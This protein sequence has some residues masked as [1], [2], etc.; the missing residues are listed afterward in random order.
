MEITRGWRR[1]ISVIDALFL[2]E[3]RARFSSSQA[4]LFW[5]FFQ[6]FFMTSMFLTMHMVL[7]GSDSSSN[8]VYDYAVFLVLSMTSFFLFRDTLG[9]SAGAFTG[10]KS[11]F[12]YRRVKPVDTIVARMLVEIFIMSIIMSIFIIIGFYLGRDM[13]AKNLGMV[14]LG[15]IWL[16]VFG[17]GLG[18]LVAIG[19]VFY[20]FVGKLVGYISMPLLFLSGV[21]Y[22]IQSVYQVSPDVAQLL[23]YNPLVH[24]MEMIHGNYFYDL[25]DRF[26][27][28]EYM[29][30]WTAV[31]LF[32]GLWLYI[33][34][35]KRIVSS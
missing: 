34:L 3:L 13:H 7:R 14:F 1:Q 5:T 8:S 6:P 35:E 4:G 11:L 9:K 17:F 31:T 24:F 33:F 25:D 19:N 18:L 16:F 15:Y 30:I 22:S 21:F 29:A 10:N 23:L 27:D 12:I 20:D 26:V 32:S 28:Y 2:R